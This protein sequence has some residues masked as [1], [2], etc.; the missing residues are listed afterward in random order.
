MASAELLVP[1][2]VRAV[3]PAGGGGNNRIYRVECAN[4]AFALKW[5]PAQDDDRRERLRVEFAALRFLRRHGVE[6]VPQA[7]VADYGRG[8]GV[9]EWL[10]GGPAGAPGEADVDAALRFVATLAELSGRKEAAALPLA[11]AAC[12]SGRAVMDQAE[13]RLARLRQVSAAEPELE[14]FLDRDLAPTLEEI[15]AWA[16]ARFA[17]A[18][19]DFEAEL[20]PGERVLS[21][22]DFGFHNALRRADGGLV[23]FDLEY[24]GWDD[25]AKLVADFLHH[26]GMALEPGLKRRFLEGA[27]A[28]LEHLGGFPLRFP[29]LFPLYGLCWCLILLN[30]F[31]PERWQRRALAGAEDRRRITGRQLERARHL[32]AT[33]RESY[34]AGPS[35]H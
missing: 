30:E 31:L 9:Y 34:E 17:R 6:A 11:S 33:L 25:P 26:P 32:H 1:G 3:L 13:A 28:A 24:F 4:G 21:A 35:I 29:I 16:A 14:A 15:G 8:L 5:Y 19:L 20:G 23:F 2:Q 7:F 27:G 18:E 22:S 10:D 12:L